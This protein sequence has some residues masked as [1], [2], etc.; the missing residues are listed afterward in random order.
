MKP[1]AMSNDPL[2]KIY[3][4]GTA[5]TALVIGGG[6]LI[7]PQGTSSLIRDAFPG[8]SWYVVFAFLFLAGIA[9]MVGPFLRT[10]E[11]PALTVAGFIVIS[12]FLGAYGVA[13]LGQFGI[14]ALTAAAAPLMMALT[15]LTRTVF[16]V[17]DANR[18]QA[19]VK[20]R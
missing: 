4:T 8:A 20:G 14:T 17:R 5:M 9:A 1:D 2:R 12:T 7:F 16:I 15:N 18:A 11:G 13:L 6:G 3:Q 10:I 19:A